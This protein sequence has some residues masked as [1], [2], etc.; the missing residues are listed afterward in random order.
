MPQTKQR[1]LAACLLVFL[2][3]SQSSTASPPAEAQ[4]WAG[5]GQ[6]DVPKS[7]SAQTLGSRSTVTSSATLYGGF[8]LA[9]SALVFILV[10]GNSLGT[11]GVTQ[12][13]LDAPR[14]RLFNAQGADLIFDNSGQPGFNYCLTTGPYSGPLRIYYSIVRGQPADD[15]DACTS[16]TLNPGTYTFF[17][18]PSALSVHPSGE[19]LF[20]VTLNP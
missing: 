16:N 14:L 5:Q 4:A 9:T 8:Q 20:E 6:V 11:L 1:H 10:R 3:L 2:A 7:A 18:T 12:N 13:Y 19:V 17:I 15:R